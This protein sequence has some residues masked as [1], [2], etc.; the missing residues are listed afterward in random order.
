MARDSYTYL[1]LP[2]I[3][4]II[5]FAIG[6]RRTLLHVSLHL[7]PVIAVALCGGVAVYLVALS[8]FKRRNIGSFNRQRL[9]VATVLCCL[10]PVTIRIPA[11][12]ALGMVTTAAC[13]LI[14]FEFIRYSETRERIRHGTRRS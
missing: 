1:H 11:L 14:A 9:V 10:I 8:A 7:H 5:L 4:G 12:A 2:M 13:G 6:V 3:T